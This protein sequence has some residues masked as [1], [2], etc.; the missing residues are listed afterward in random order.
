MSASTTF[1]TRFAAAVC[2]FALSV[3]TIGTTVTVPPAQ[4]HTNVFASGYV[5]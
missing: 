3:L 2:A 4:A 5:A 1:G